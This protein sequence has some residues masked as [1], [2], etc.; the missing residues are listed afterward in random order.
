VF[1][2]QF[3]AVPEVWNEKTVAA[4]MV[5]KRALLKEENERCRAEAECRLE[6]K[7]LDQHIQ[8]VRDSVCSRTVPQVF[9]CKHGMLLFKYSIQFIIN[10]VKSIQGAAFGCRTCHLKTA[11]SDRSI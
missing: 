1:I 7:K 6:I 3:V 8:A 11:S 5:I 10:S 2:L 4:L 9:T